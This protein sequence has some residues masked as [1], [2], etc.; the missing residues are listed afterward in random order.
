[1]RVCRFRCDDLILTG[2]Y[3]DNV[4]IPLDQAADMY[5]RETDNEMLLAATEDLL[6]L[7][8]PG[9]ES[10]EQAR[11]LHDWIEELDVI[12]LNE[13]TI[14]REEVQLLVPLPSPGKLL[15]LAGNYSKHL[16]ERGYTST[17]RDETFPYVFMKPPSTTLTHPGDPIVI[18]RISPDQ[19]DWECELGVVVGKR[20][21]D[22]AE[23]D[24][25]DYVAGYTVVNDVS[26]RSFRPNPG[27]KPRE[28]DKF[29]DWLHGK[30]HDTFCPMGPCI[31]SA[32]AVADP[33]ALAIKLTVNGQVKQDASTAEMVFP[34]AAVVSF[35]SRFVTLEPGDV[36]ATGTPS[37]VGSSTGTFL[38]PGDRV[39]A[40]IA[41]IGTLENPVQ[42]ENE[43][44]F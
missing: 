11:R 13:L 12:S 9:G 36:I 44:E 5:S 40:T 31:L 2:F 14:P 18:P 24:A 39:R 35:V 20:C 16:V 22:V 19:I 41:T 33:Q 15:F 7:L 30:W 34:V 28:R 32:D 25:L 26:D 29:F 3:G 43:D 23:A 38:K 4:V 1:M 27:R 21:R 8:P 37:G 17:E 10:Y 42:A 6:D